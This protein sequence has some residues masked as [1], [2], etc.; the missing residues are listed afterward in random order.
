MEFDTSCEPDEKLNP[1]RFD[2]CRHA[3]PWAG[4]AVEDF[5]GY[6]P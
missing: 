4:Q 5:A 2:V 3:L 1:A 6:F